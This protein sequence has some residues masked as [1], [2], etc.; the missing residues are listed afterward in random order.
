MKKR[1]ISIMAVLLILAGAVWLT[2]CYQESGISAE[3][4]TAA[5]KTIAAA[6]NFLDG[7]LSSEEASD[8]VLSYY[9]NVNPAEQDDGNSAVKS[10][11]AQVLAALHGEFESREGEDLFASDEEKQQWEENR[12]EKVLQRRNNLARAIGAKER[13]GETEHEG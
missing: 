7:K 12:R 6:D 10:H 5:K 4:R 13:I 8:E 2:G 9:R 1:S 3:A 11:I